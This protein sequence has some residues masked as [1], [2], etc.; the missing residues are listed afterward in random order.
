M[1]TFEPRVQAEIAEEL[2]SSATV[3][4][5]FFLDA[6]VGVLGFRLGKFKS[7]TPLCIFQRACE[8]LLHIYR[9]R[10]NPVTK[11]VTKMDSEPWH[12]LALLD[13]SKNVNR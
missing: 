11:N 12:F 8:N 2:G 10:L 3:L 7:L 4:G 9:K 6:R 5:L 13:L 1:R